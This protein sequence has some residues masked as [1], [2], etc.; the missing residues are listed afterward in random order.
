MEYV[1]RYVW[2]AALGPASSLLLLGGKCIMEWRA[3]VRSNI[4]F[5]HCW[6]IAK[7][8]R[9]KSAHI[10]VFSSNGNQ[11]DSIL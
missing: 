2:K 4:V 11:I 9:S 3:G 10:A 8:C 5:S 1:R 6:I 7:V